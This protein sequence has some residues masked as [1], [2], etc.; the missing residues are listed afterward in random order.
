MLPLCVFTCF[1]CVGLGLT[2]SADAEGNG[3]SISQAVQAERIA[4]LTNVLNQVEPPLQ[5]QRRAS[6]PIHHASTH[7][8]GY[9]SAP[10][11]SP[12]HTHPAAQPSMG[13]ADRAQ[14]ARS[15]MDLRAQY[16]HQQEAARP[17]YQTPVY[18]PRDMSPARTSS[19][20]PSPTSALLPSC[21]QDVIQ[22]SPRQ[23]SPATSSS[24]AD[25][26]F[27]EYELAYDLGENYEY[28][29]TGAREV[30]AGAGARVYR[31]GAAAAASAGGS[32]WKLDGEETKNLSLPKAAAPNQQDLLEL[33]GRIN[34]LT[35]IA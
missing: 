9:T 13:M 15:Q 32:I 7:A 6:V 4:L 34:G 20:V 25:L 35:L 11:P 24:S 22:T 14:R 17:I 12:L 19:R 29:G 10:G 5:L 16:V 21:L 18:S 31:A 23:S 27:E 33:A 8:P 3:D 26:S 28:A 1:S 2:G 30:G